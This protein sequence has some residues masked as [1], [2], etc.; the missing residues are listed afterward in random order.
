MTGSRK[1]VLITVV[2][3]AAVVAA[4]VIG[5]FQLRDMAQTGVSDVPDTIV[6]R[7]TD[8]ESKVTASGNFASRDPVTVGS[9]ALAG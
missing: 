4:G 8:L 2:V 9:N 5:F 1:K 7:K 6:L 3:I